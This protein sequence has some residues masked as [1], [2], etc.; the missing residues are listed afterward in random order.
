[1]FPLT[2]AIKMLFN[3]IKTSREELKIGPK[4][5]LGKSEIRSIMLFLRNNTTIIPTDDEIK[6]L[7]NSMVNKKKKVRVKYEQPSLYSD[8]KLNDVIKIVRNF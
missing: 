7:W 6:V 1:M 8:A 5:P 2:V 4:E 3:Q